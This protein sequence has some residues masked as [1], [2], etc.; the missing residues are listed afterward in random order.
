MVTFFY[1]LVCLQ[2]PTDA[3]LQGANIS[4]WM[5]EICN[6]I[7]NK[8]NLPIKVRSPQLERKFEQYY[9]EKTLDIKDLSFEKGTKQNLF[10]SID[11]SIFVCSFSSGIGIDS[12]IRGKPVVVESKASFVFNIRTKLDDALKGDFNLTDR[13]QILSNISYCQWNLEE[14]SKGLPWKHLKTQIK[15]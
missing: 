2:L 10:D 5:W 15:N 8:S 14:I 13:L 9:L 4:K 6:K 7:R 1:I 11:N 3:S 12:L